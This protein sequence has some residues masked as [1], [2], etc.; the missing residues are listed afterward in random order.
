VLDF[1]RNHFELLGLP[2]GYALDGD[3][4]AERFH[5][6]QSAVHPDRFASAPDQERRLSMQASTRVNEAF[7]TLKNP[8]AR[9]LYLLTLYPDP[10]PQAAAQDTAFLMEQMELRETLAEA[11][12]S[13]DPQGAVAGVLEHIVRSERVIQA[14]L[15]RLFAD[16]APED[17]AAA[18]AAVQKLQ[19]LD[20]CRR[21]AEALEAELELG[22]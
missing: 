19:F 2:V 8:L 3:L 10:G 11:T 5:A 1:S 22:S 20:K 12:S 18:H 17:L 6:L 9:A 13:P 21:D 15:C 16:H 7:Q 14:N 4:L